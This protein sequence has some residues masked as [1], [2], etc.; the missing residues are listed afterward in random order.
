MADELPFET[1]RGRLSPEDLTAIA[2]AVA[3]RPEL[4]VGEVNQ[5]AAERAYSDVFTNEH[6]ESFCFDD[7]FIH[8]MRR[9]P[10]AD[11]TITIHAY[12]PPLRQTG[13]YGECE[14][15][16]LHRTPTDAVEQLKPHGVQG[17]STGHQQFARS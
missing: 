1:Q 15:G 14:D 8:R 3:T 4:R 10:G 9:D 17:T 11:S 5:T 13:Q 2:E 16:L 6:L 7:T 12:S